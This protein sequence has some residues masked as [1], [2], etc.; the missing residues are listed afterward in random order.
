M[1]RRRQGS[2]T[3]SGHNTATTMRIVGGD[4][5]GRK[6][7]YAGDRV[8]RPMKDRTREAVFNLIGPTVK[9]THVIDLFAG[10]GAMAL[11][12]CSRGA[13]SGTLIERHVPS[14]QNIQENFAILSLEDV[15]ELFCAN[16]FLWSRTEIVNLPRK[17]WLIFCCPPYQFFTEKR[18]ELIELL[19]RLAE[20]APPDSLLVVEAETPFDFAVLKLPGEWKTRCY[21]PAEVGILDLNPTTSN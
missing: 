13:T 5:R 6:I 17:R 18:D 3:D 20:A 9:D 7:I 10:T 16:V 19:H 2:R 21:R 15:C 4:L 12:S 1:G 8:V 14:A 11:E